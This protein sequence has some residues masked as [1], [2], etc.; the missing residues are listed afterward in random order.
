MTCST[1]R[2]HC[3]SRD[4][5]GLPEPTPAPRMKLPRMFRPSYDVDGPHRRRRPLLRRLFAALF[6]RST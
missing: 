5:C 1:C 2:G 6:R 4:A 3:P